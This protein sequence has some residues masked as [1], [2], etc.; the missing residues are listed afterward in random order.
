M[1]EPAAPTERIESIDVLRGVALCGILMVNIQLFAMIEATLFNPGAYGDLTGANLGVWVAMRLFFDQKF[2]TIFSPLFGAGIALMAERASAAGKGSAGRHYRRMFWLALFG[3]SHGLLLWY[4]EI[5]FLYSICGS[6]AYLFHRLRPRW[7]L[8]IGLFV[9]SIAAA[10]SVLGGLSLPTW[11]EEARQSMLADITPAPADVDAEVAAYRGGWSAQMEYRVPAYTNFITMVLL[12]WG[13]WRAWGLMLI[14]MALMKLRFF[15][16]SWSRRAYAT[17]AALAGGLGFALV[18][19]D[20]RHNWNRWDELETFF[21]GQQFNY[22]GS[23]GVSLAYA[24]LVMLW[25][26]GGTSRL[27]SAFAA[28]GRMALT[29]YLLH[30]LICTTIFYG[31]GLGMFGKIERVG[32]AAIVVSIWILQ[33][34]LSPLWLERF[35]FGPFEWLWRSLT[36]WKLQPMRR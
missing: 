34:T 8:P 26:Q 25:C 31:H 27:K 3:L 5:L 9:L 30:T 24:A 6:L 10:F 33:L 19:W 1:I 16:A 14:G 28:V 17:T 35:R 36:Y 29:N 12:F 32:Q 7:L 23:L 2:M 18:A 15:S 21:L 11:P 20:V 13:L 4:G 22:W